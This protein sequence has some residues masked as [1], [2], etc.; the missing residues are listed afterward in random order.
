MILYLPCISPLCPT[1]LFFPFVLSSELPSSVCDFSRSF[2]RWRHD[3]TK[4]PLLTASQPP[5]TTLNNVRMPLECLI[6]LSQ[7]GKRIEFG[8]SASCKT[9]QVFVE[10]DVWMQPNADMCAVSSANQFMVIKRWDK[11]DKGVMLHPPSLGAQPERQY[12]NPAVAFDSHSLVLRRRS[13]RRIQT[14]EEILEVLLSDEEVVSRTRY[15]CELG[16]VFLEYPVKTVNFSERHCYYQ[17]DT[18]PVLFVGEPS[19]PALIEHL[20][21]AYVA[22]LGRSWAEFLVSR[23]TSL[24]RTPVSVHHY[25]EVRRVEASNSLWAVDPD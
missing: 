13:A 9:E 14:I 18:G 7:D 21:L 22:H 6:I 20:H 16:E 17:V 24:E 3:T 12:I 19:G 23:P 25:S 2:I 4:K 10:R 5:P 1:T 11:T 8:L 15:F